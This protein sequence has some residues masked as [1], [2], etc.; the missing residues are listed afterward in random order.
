MAKPKIIAKNETKSLADLSEKENKLY[1]KIAKQ[2]I[3]VMIDN[4]LHNPY[5]LTESTNFNV[6]KNEEQIVVNQDI[7]SFFLCKNMLSP[8][9]IQELKKLSKSL[10]VEVNN[11][12]KETRD[13][14]Y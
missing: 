14:D 10:T 12:M 8:D 1:T 7:L 4:L 9:N 3:R 6:A 5:D 2:S 11:W 13:N